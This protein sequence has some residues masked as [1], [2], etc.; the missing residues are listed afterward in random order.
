MRRV[1]S[2]LSTLVLTTTLLAVPALAQDGGD[3][4][5]R[6]DGDVGGFLNIMPPGQTGVLNTAELLAAQGGRF[7]EHFNDQ[8]GM[9]E[10]LVYEAGLPVPGD[11]GEPFLGLTDGDIERFFKDG[12]FGAAG[13]VVVEDVSDCGDVVAFRD[14]AFGV[15]H[16]YGQT[17]EAAQCANGYLTA[18]DRLFL[19]D[20]LRHVGRARLSEFL[21]AS[22]ANKA[23]DRSQLLV[24]PYDEADFQQQAADLCGSSDVERK[25]TCDDG[26]AYIEGV[27]RYI[28]E[29]QRDPRLL[30][31]E[32]LALQVIPEEF[33]VEDIIAIASLVGGIFGK[34]GGAEAANSM[35]L[36]ALIEQHGPTAG[37][38]IFDDLKAAN[39]PDAS[40]TIQASFPYND[41]DDIDD[42]TTALLQPG[43]FVPP[44][45]GGGGGGGGLPGPG[46][47]PLPTTLGIVDGPF[48]P[49]DLRTPLAMSNAILAGA[50]VSDGGVPI[51]V[52]G[53]QTG[54][55][56]PQLLVE[57]D[58]HAPGLDARGVA[59]AG[60]NI[61]VQLGRGRDYAWSATSASGDL[62]DE[63]A[64]ELCEP[65]GGSPTIESTGYVWEGVCSEIPILTHT[66]FAKPSAGGL[67]ASPSPDNIVFVLEIGQIPE[68]NDA[69]VVGR[70]L[71]V[72]GT[73]VLIA[74]QRSTFKAEL[75]SAIGF[76]RIN[77]PDFMT[78]GV[79]SFNRAFDGVDYTFNWFYIDQQ[80]IAYRHT[81]LCP[82][83][84]P[85]TDPDVLTWGGRGV[86]W[87]GQF[88]TPAQQPQSVNPEEGFYANW[89]NKQANDF[90]SQDDSFKHHSTDRREHL[91]QR[92]EAAIASGNP[93]TRG[94]MVNI[95]EDA[96]T[97]DFNPQEI[98]G[99]ALQI[100]GEGPPAAL[101]GDGRL[102]EMR[103][104][105]TSWVAAGGH[106]R[107]VDFDGV[108]DHAVAVAIGDVLVRPMI[109]GVLGDQI[110]LEL[111]PEGI[112]DHP[113]LGVGSA[114][115]SGRMRFL[116]KDF[117]QVL[118]LPMRQ[119]RSRTYC[120]DGTV[121]GCGAVLWRALADA[122]VL[123]ESEADDEGCGFPAAY[124]FGSP[125]VS[126]WIYGA[127]CDN[128]V[129]RAAGVVA[130]PSMRWVNR[131][132]FQQVVQAG[133]DIGRI[134]GLTR[135]TTATSLSRHAWPEGSDVVV[136]AAAGTFPD[137][138][139]GTPLAAANDAPLLLTD[140][141]QLSPATR[142]EIA[143]LGASRAIVLGGTAAVDSVVV[144]ALEVDGLTVQ[145]VAGEDRFATAVAIA[146]ELG[147]TDRFVVANGGAF[148]DALAAGPF[149]VSD[150]RA[151][152]LV[153]TDSV[154]PVVAEALQGATDIV[155]AGGEAA[156]DAAVAA[157]LPGTVTRIG[158]ENRYATALGFAEAA[159]E[160]GLG[161]DVVYAVTGENFPDALAAGATAIRADAS[162]VLLQPDALEN[163]A[164]NATF[165]VE[166]ASRVWLAGG[167]AALPSALRAQLEARL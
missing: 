67:P 43:S 111:W 116:Q 137:A 69:P 2:L 88:L 165:I 48:G 112:E 50:D 65:G 125:T 19:M 53:P 9:Y 149:A 161:D 44:F 66:Q 136:I 70:A 146:A 83:R 55:F 95:M 151:I 76:Q 156:V 30:P 1:I 16:I 138:V 39:D 133:S 157:S 38:L 80:D 77:D 47:L 140:R 120:A 97:V 124:Q 49:L 3:G 57:T 154:P 119:Q 158:G 24:A 122:A 90:R 105:L 73:P 36:A 92:I 147:Q 28:E 93:L 32:Y 10:D 94:D 8:T 71:T 34:G 75:D 31:G 62:V 25:R 85:S 135:I 41:H 134:N 29:A 79:E 128:I 142:Y 107:D 42:T 15:P 20:L 35:F 87:T 110:P 82:V 132:T 164:A 60:T 131:P 12:S 100:M 123:L 166:R 113:R 59:F 118:D 72:D 7:P 141:D 160:A 126:D 13:D 21:G 150:D 81:C 101:A 56:T 109:E 86:Q 84:D 17:R 121:A 61:Y 58:I 91:S 99:L 78:D 144:E 103:D 46:D 6:Q 22:E 163:A 106:R 52:F 4:R 162:L 45:E 117:W 139:A 74:E 98:Y 130:A 64:L 40:L 129:Q 143:R 54:Y 102:R 127:D 155:I 89:N 18:A 114:Y 37:R 63:W 68:L 108:Y 27:N 11:A 104:L 51:A 96:G 153:S 26:T 159:V 23:M 14:T 33:I 152:L 148:P 145:R 167:E 5:H 115:N